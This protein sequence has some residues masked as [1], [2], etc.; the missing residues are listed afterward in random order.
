MTEM[1][2]STQR[3]KGSALDHIDLSTVTSQLYI[4]EV[5]RLLI[6]DQSVFRCH[7]DFAPSYFALPGA[8]FLGKSPSPGRFPQEYRPPSSPPSRDITADYS[9]LFW[10]TNKCVNIFIYS[11]DRLTQ[12]I[13]ILTIRVNFTPICHSVLKQHE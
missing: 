9:N 10:F 12:Q 2:S 3:F 11:S 7:R 5:L 13:K 4:P 8:K 1:M 6:T